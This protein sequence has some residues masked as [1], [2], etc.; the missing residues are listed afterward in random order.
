MPAATPPRL[1]ILSFYDIKGDPRIMKQVLRFAEEY[2]VTTC[3]PGPSPDPRVTHIALDASFTP[4]RGRI[5]QA[6]D[7]FVREREWFRFT[8]RQVPTVA[9]MR[10]LLRGRRFDA[11]LAN[12]VETVGVALE[13]AG[14]RRVH[15]DLHEFFPGLPQPDD[16]LGRRQQRYVTW[17]TERHAARAASATTVGE[18][19]A[20]RYRPYGVSAEVV[21]NSPRYSARRPT[22]TG[23]PIRLVH[24]GHP[25]RRRGIETMMRAVAKSA[26]QMTLDLYLVHSDENE[27][28]RL[29]GIADELGSRITIH[30]PVPLPELVDTLAAYDVGIFVLP[31]TS[32]NHE[33][34][35]PNKFF[36][37]IQARLAVVIGP[38]V[39]MA[40]IVRRHGL[41]VIAD[42]FSEEATTA[43]LD[44]LSAE[45]VDAFK[46]A[47]DSAASDL[48]A[49]PQIEVWA[50]AIEEIVGQ[51]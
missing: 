49:E 28:G 33:L 41:G 3:S 25:F 17:M 12:D 39:E 50:R 46:A 42:D 23:T 34:A 16:E 35:L 47:S 2:D 15:T 5:A 1:L 19:I 9:Q 37:F 13:V 10:L 32:V 6:V 31:P 24:H 7:A 26:A 14:P 40:R 21:T 38:S 18:E 8:Y 22:A 4:R 51:R 30:E 44:Q 48:S 45:R 27:L 29:R 20:A 36:D 11:V 43:A